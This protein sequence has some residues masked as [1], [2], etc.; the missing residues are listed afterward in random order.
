MMKKPMLYH[1]LL[2]LNGPNMNLLGMRDPT[3]YG[4]WTLADVENETRNA[5]MTRG[6]KLDA[7]QSNHE[8]RLIDLI[9]E[10]R[11]RYDGIL[12]NAAALTHTSIA[13]RDAIEACSIPVY[14]VHMSD[15]QKREPF[16][17][18]SVIEP[19]CRAQISG[20]GL[21]SYLV[22]LEQLCDWL[23]DRPAHPGEAQAEGVTEAQT[24]S[25][26]GDETAKALDL[27]DLRRQI[28]EIDET[29]LDQFSRRTGIVRQVAAY[30][31]ERHIPVLDLEREA[32]VAATARSRYSDADGMRAESLMKNVMRLSREAQYDDRDMDDPEWVLGTAIRSAP[33]KHGPI[34]K[35]VCQGS[36]GAYSMAAGALLFPDAERV[37]AATFADACALVLDGQADVA[38][39]PWE[40]STAGT[41]DEVY[42]L[43]QENRLFI[44]RC[45]SL[46]IGHTLMSLPGTS[47]DRIKTIVSHPQALAQCQDFIRRQGAVIRESTNTA[48]AAELVATSGDPTLAAIASAQAAKIHG[49]EILADGI[50]DLSHNQTRFIVISRTLVIPHDADRVSLILSLPHQS[51]SLASTLSVFGDRGLN[52]IK[53]QSRPDP[54]K[55]WNYRFHIDFESPN[56]SLE[57]MRALYQ[58]D[59]EMPFL[60][61]LGWYRE[62]GEPFGV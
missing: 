62:S 10:A 50:Q 11:L 13:I 5:A 36:P 30:K 2:L 3:Q 47:L 38:V 58:L 42:S 23:E 61:L 27:R 7:M 12:L 51:G 4:H 14:E 43:L 52:L 59:R 57:A 29:L 54:L 31:I 26:S 16:R 18:L 8:G 6:F 33:S 37:C 17:R 55:A 21:K 35:V 34:R 46:A 44:I 24:K 20:L 40:N 45:A 22:A 15:I 48:F 53:I 28:S 49:L 41:V 1:R 9:Q 25:P 32:S 19:V 39:L 56:G 60:K